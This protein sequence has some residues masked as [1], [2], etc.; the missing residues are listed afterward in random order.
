MNAETPRARI[1]DIIRNSGKMGAD[2]AG[3]T[4]DQLA[5]IAAAL[6]GGVSAGT[7]YASEALAN[8]LAKRFPK[9]SPSAALER[10]VAAPYER[11]AKALVLAL[12]ACGLNVA[13]AFDTESGAMLEVKKP[14]SLL[15]P[16]YAIT[17]TVL[18]RGFTT[19]FIGQATHTGM[20]L[21]RN[22]K[23]LTQLFDRTND[24]LKLMSS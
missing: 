2:Q 17:L 9:L 5:A 18:D 3:V 4:N 12:Q 1:A 6:G 19:H 14:M 20:D 21:G 24:Y 8:E 10:D 11:A 22:A 15:A 7:V 23:L 13:A 16:P